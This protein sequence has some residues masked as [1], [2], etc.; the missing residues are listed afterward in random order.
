MSS[1][2]TSTQEIW[3]LVVQRASRMLFPEMS[4]SGAG[5]GKTMDNNNNGFAELLARERNQC[6]IRAGPG[7]DGFSEEGRSSLSRN[8]CSKPQ[9]DPACSL[10]RRKGRSRPIT[11][12]GTMRIVKS[13]KGKSDPHSLGLLGTARHGRRVGGNLRRTTVKNTKNLLDKG[14]GR[15]RTHNKETNNSTLP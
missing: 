7:V 14:I 10:G 4:N 2:E 13:K 9:C 1:E 3:R 12:E 11:R 8:C 5:V 6:P 15:V